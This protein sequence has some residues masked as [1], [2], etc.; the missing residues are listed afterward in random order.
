MRR[1]N[2]AITGDGVAIIEYRCHLSAVAH[3]DGVGLSP[4]GRRRR[5]GLPVNPPLV[6][7]TGDARTVTGVGSD[8]NCGYGS[9]RG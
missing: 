8:R 2:Y 3:S 4:K 9:L 1:C 6:A 7:A 5:L